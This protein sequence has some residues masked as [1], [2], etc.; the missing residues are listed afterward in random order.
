MGALSF[1]LIHQEY[2]KLVV[3]ESLHT[4]TRRKSPLLPTAAAPRR[5]ECA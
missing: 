1:F 4:R 5:A 3:V 2:A